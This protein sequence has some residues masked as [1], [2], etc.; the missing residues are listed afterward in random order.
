MSQTAVVSLVHLIEEE[1]LVI[2]AILTPWPNNWGLVSINHVSINHSYWWWTSHFRVPKTQFI[3]GPKRGKRN[4]S[5]RL[6]R[7]IGTVGN[8]LKL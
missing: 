6:T 8:H 2:S 5:N 1:S 4:I 3:A 7:P